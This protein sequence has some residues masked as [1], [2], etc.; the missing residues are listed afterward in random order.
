MIIG[1]AIYEEGKNIYNFSQVFEKFNKFTIEHC[2]LNTNNEL[3]NKRQLIIDTTDPIY[4][5]AITYWWLKTNLM[6]SVVGFDVSIK[7]SENMSYD[8][9]N[10]LTAYAEANM[11]VSVM[12]IKYKGQYILI[13]GGPIKTDLSVEIDKDADAYS[14]I[15]KYL[16][17][18][19]SQ[20][21]HNRIHFLQEINNQTLLETLELQ[22]DV[23]TKTVIELAS[24][25]NI[26][27]TE[28]STLLNNSAMIKENLSDVINHVDKQKSARR[29]SE[30]N[31]NQTISK[32]LK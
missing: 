27:V 1:R 21:I 7:I 19:F 25:N 29:N 16:S 15:T 8:V 12:F 10:K 3:E 17:A 23:L 28:L 11:V 9:L 6:G 14:L 2:Q 22:L 18:D 13:I 30:T 31:F 20:A 5:D 32:F 26:D 4:D 24:K